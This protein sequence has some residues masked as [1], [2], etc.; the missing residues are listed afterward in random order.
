MIEAWRTVPG[1]S[2]YEVS[3]TGKLRRRPRPGESGHVPVSLTTTSHGYQVA[4][5]RPTMA[6]PGQKRPQFTVHRIVLTAF[7][8][9][10]PRDKP[11]ACHINGNRQDNRLENL[12]WG[13][14]WENAQDKHRHGTT[15]WGQKINT[16]KLTPDDV[17]IIRARLAAGEFQR[18]IAA[19]F[20]VNQ[21]AIWAINARKSWRRLDNADAMR[22]AGISLE[23]G[24]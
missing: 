17:R 2:D 8:G 3:N 5:L 16:N 6:T 4:S 24:A 7:V 19:D 9:H 20:G 14:A 11:Q 23:R 21:Y 12:R 15:V 22:E 13:N 1:F 18:A 10:P